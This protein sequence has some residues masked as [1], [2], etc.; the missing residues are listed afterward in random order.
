MWAFEDA[1][2]ASKA[3]L[4]DMKDSV[5]KFELARKFEYAEWRRKAF[6]ELVKRLEPLS[7]DEARRIG[8]EATTQIAQ[9]R[10][11]RVKAKA[12]EDIAASRGT[13]KLW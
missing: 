1:L 7:I 13:S 10:E 5:T 8:L 4:V 11:A 6:N 2:A 12:S 3:F 9:F